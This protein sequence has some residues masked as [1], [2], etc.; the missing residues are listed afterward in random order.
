MYDKQKITYYKNIRITFFEPD[1][2]VENEE[3]N[4]KN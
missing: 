4:R 3:E 2:D 1:V